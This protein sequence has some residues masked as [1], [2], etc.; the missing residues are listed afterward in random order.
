VFAVN[1]GLEDGRRVVSIEV[2]VFTFD[3]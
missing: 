1:V 2:H 3:Q